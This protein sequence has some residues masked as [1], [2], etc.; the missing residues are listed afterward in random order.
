MSVEVTKRQSLFISCFWVQL[1]LLGC[2]LRSEEHSPSVAEGKVFTESTLREAYYRPNNVEIKH[3]RTHHYVFLD[4]GQDNDAELGEA[5]RASL[6]QLETHEAQATMRMEANG[7]LRV[8]WDRPYKKGQVP[9]SRLFTELGST[10]APQLKRTIESAPP[11]VRQLLPKNEQMTGEYKIV[12]HLPKK[13][14]L[15]MLYWHTDKGKINLV[16]TFLAGDDG[17]LGTRVEG[18]AQST[19]GQTAALRGNGSEVNDPFDH[20]IS[21]TQ[22]LQFDT[23]QSY[24]GDRVLSYWLPSYN[25]V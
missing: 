6:Q 23:T 21:H 4:T 25:E 14:A 16:K 20:P 15:P 10:W 12:R 18:G 8:D 5:I 9:V 17:S 2:D 24:L 3:F 7:L 22:S 13:L 1:S 19:A 11:I